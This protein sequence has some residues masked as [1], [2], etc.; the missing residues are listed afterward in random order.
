MAWVRSHEEPEPGWA[1]TSINGLCDGGCG[2][3]TLEGL[4]ETRIPHVSS[5]EL[6]LAI[7][8]NHIAHNA[9]YYELYT[10][11]LFQLFLF[12]TVL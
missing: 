5:G 12:D 2:T 10:L 7:T 11:V 9:A 3:W 1:S 8:I 4:C 6:A